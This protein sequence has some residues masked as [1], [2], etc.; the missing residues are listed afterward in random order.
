MI[1]EILT[2]SSYTLEDFLLDHALRPRNLGELTEYNASAMVESPRCGD[3]MRVYLQINEDRIIVDARF[4]VF[5]CGASIAAGSLTTEE[6]KGK[7]IAEATDLLDTVR[8][9]FDIA[10]PKVVTCKQL[11][12][13]AVKDALTRYQSSI[14]L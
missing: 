13:E 10:E 12:P 6:I 7:T 3:V 1:E 8:R 9:I 5:G 2:D 4:K 14:D 11:A